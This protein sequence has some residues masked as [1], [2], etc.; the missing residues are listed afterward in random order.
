MR[1]LTLL[2]VWAWSV[3]AAPLTV[4]TWNLQWFP[5]GTALK[6]PEDTELARI[7]E[8]AALIRE[9]APDV[10]VAQEIRDFDA[11]HRLAR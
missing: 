5:S 7:R 11:A 10:L 4:L 3:V 2:T 6:A 8:A 9:I 1:W